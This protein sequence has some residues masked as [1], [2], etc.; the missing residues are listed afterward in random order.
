MQE[1]KIYSWLGL[2]MRSGNLVSGD[3]TTLRD[4]KKMRLSLIIIADDASA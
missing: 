4:L 2:A 3:D 1:K